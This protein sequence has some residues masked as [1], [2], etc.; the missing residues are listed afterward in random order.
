[1]FRHV[2]APSRSIS[3]RRVVAMAS[4]L[5]LHVRH[6]LQGRDLLCLFSKTLANHDSLRPCQFYWRCWATAGKVYCIVVPEF[7]GSSTS[8]RIHYKVD[9][10]TE[11][12]AS[13]VHYLHCT[14]RVQTDASHLTMFLIFPWNVGFQPV[15]FQN[16]IQSGR[17]TIL[18]LQNVPA[19]ARTELKILP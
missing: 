17:G 19:T 14:R 8:L 18:Q 16:L 10:N 4:H 15:R 11:Y 9:Q 6:K 13:L 7:S 5:N 12:T 2:Q 1:M 3:F